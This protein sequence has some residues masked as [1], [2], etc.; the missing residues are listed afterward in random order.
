MREQ[1]REIQ[2]QR[3]TN[4]REYAMVAVASGAGV[5]GVFQVLRGCAGAGGQTMKPSIDDIKNPYSR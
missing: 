1:N 4:E 5:G 2:A 3:K